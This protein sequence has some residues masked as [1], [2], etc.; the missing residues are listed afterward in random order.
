M[1]VRWRDPA[2]RVTTGAGEQKFLM[3]IV[4]GSAPGGV[5]GTMNES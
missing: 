5:F 2:S 4:R 1:A 3:K